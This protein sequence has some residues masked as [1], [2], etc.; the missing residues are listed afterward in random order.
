MGKEDEG[1]RVLI[2]NRK[3]RGRCRRG[4]EMKANED[5]RMNED[6][7]ALA[8]EKMGVLWGS[9]GADNCERV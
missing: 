6:G 1:K 9:W 8:S 2:A 7:G 4:T 5:R 3:R